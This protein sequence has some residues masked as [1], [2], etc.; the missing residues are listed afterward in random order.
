M[1]APRDLGAA[2]SRSGVDGPDHRKWGKI[3]QREAGRESEKEKCTWDFLQR[4]KETDA[5]LVKQ[6]C[7]LSRALLWEQADFSICCSAA[8]VA[9]DLRTSM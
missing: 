2:A 6:Q 1:L 7:H 9:A 4:G 8:A 3:P 5:G